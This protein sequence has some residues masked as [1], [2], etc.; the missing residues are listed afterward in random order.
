MN[1]RQTRSCPER[2]LPSEAQ[3]ARLSSADRRLG[4]ARPPSMPEDCFTFGSQHI[5][6][7]E[8]TASRTVSASPA[9]ANDA[10][11]GELA[12]ESCW[13]IHENSLAQGCL[14]GP[15]RQQV[16]EMGLVNAKQWRKIARLAASAGVGM[17]PVR[18]PQNPLRV[19]FDQR[20]CQGHHISII[21][22]LV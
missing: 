4:F 18:T 12:V 15:S 8:I 9:R 22:R 20:P 17:R 19:G 11:A 1:S 6:R 13:I 7:Y 2:R 21:G 10:V 5:A 16:Q 3:A 14:W